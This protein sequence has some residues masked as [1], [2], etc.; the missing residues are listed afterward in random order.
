MALH[1]NAFEI[2][3]SPQNTVSTR[4]QNLGD[5]LSIGVMLPACIAI[6]YG[7]G[8]LLDRWA[9]TQSVFKVVFILFGIAAGF[10]NL[11]RMVKKLSDDEPSSRNS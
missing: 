7:I 4:F 10:I 3:I 2:P 11:F 8:V 1:L 9:G 6:G 5:L